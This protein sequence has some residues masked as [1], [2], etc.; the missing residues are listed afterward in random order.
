MVDLPQIPMSILVP[1]FMEGDNLPNLISSLEDALS[2]VEFEVIII[3]DNSPDST[4]EKIKKLSER[5]RNI[6]FLVRP[7]KMG[8][9]SAY[10]DGFKVS[11]GKIIVGM[12]G[13]L[14]HNPRDLSKLV[15]ALDNADVAIGSRNI[16]GGKTCGWK[17]HRKLI[18][19]WVNFFVRNFLRL[20]I[21]DST[22]GFR[23]YR[24]KIFKLIVETS[25]F[26][27]FEFQVE[28][29]YIAQKL[30][31]RITEVPIEFS[32]RKHGRSKLDFSA[33]VNF[34]KAILKLIFMGRVHTRTPSEV[35]QHQL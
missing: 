1:T 35:S 17:P 16:D 21:R 9:G 22:S 15:D 11:C 6:R 5:H 33:C 23:A 29:I 18:N 2:E 26:N 19:I 14:S 34:V 20:R 3:D 32:D 30:G 25:M 24:R 27:G 4:T 8:L 7:S 13:D 10:K 12:D 31:V 28:S